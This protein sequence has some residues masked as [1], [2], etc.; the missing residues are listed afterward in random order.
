M[1]KLI[2]GLAAASAL[3]G[4]SPAVAAPPGGTNT[5]VINGLCLGDVGAPTV[6][7]CIGYYDKNLLNDDKQAEQQA[8]LAQIGFTPAV[9][10]FNSYKK[11]PSL[12]GSFTVDFGQKLYGITYVGLHFGGGSDPGNAT[13]FY[14]LDAGTL[15]VQTITLLEKASSGAVLYSTQA[16][17]QNN[18]VPEP[19]MWA[20][21]V[22]GFGMVG[23]AGRR[24]SR[25][26]H[27]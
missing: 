14:K 6:L 13:A 15:G 23:A 27:A 22:G 2:L 4:V 12:N 1:R 9:F 16:P 26:V 7:G 11:I 10:D 5:I 18:A 8:A 24:R 25:P 21:L 20:L 19:A 17:N 3:A